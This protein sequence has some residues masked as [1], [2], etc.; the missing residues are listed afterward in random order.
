M[1]DSATVEKIVYGGLGLAHHEGQTLFLPYTAPGDRVTFSVIKKRKNCLFGRIDSLIEPSP[2]RR[3]P[4]CPA[5]GKCGG[6]HLLHLDYSDELEVKKMSVLENLERIGKIQTGL[7][8]ILPSPSRFGYRNHAVFKT[9]R[10]GLPGF[11]MRESSS[12]VPFPARGCLLLP[13]AMRESIADLPRDAMPPLGE[14]RVRIDRFGAVRFWGLAD[15]PDPPEVLMEAGGLL[16]PV[17]PGAFFQVNRY[18]ND[19]LMELAVSLPSR[20]RRRLLDLYC[21]SGFF[22]L[23]MSRVVV[24]A[25]GIERSRPAFKNASAAARMN[26][27]T[28]VRFRNGKVESEIRRFRD[29]DI[30]IADPPRSGIPSSVI[31]EI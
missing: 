11:T 23:P 28:N 27:I 22:T 14:F 26:K 2:M 3:E 24:E 18:L 8:K 31:R 20:V 29:V 13:E 15:R 10:E 12:V 25:F 17:A 1:A 21:G 5:F 30:L 6:C 9:D 19:G 4:E 16:F 7:K